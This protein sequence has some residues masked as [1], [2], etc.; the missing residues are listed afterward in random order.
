MG[1]GTSDQ[2]VPLQMG[3]AACNDLKAAGFPVSW[4]AYQM[5]HSVCHEEIKDISSWIQKIWA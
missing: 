4:H 1:H 5:A 2:I 3:F